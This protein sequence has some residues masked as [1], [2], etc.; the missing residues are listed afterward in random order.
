MPRV[1]MYIVIQLRSFFIFQS[2]F[3]FLPRYRLHRPRVITQP[4]ESHST[5]LEHETL[6]N[7]IQ[8]YDDPDK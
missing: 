2:P 7:K 6:E 3:L 4:F 8:K 1:L 5:L